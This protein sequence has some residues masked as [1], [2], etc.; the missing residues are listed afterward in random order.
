MA[1]KDRPMGENLEEVQDLRHFT[2]HA[3]FDAGDT[4]IV[5]RRLLVEITDSP[6]SDEKKQLF[7]EYANGLAEHVYQ[8]ILDMCVEPRE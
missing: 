1:G 8:R 2:V 5:T 3:V 4:R 7:R 6:P